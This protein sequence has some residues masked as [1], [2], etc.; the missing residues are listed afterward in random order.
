MATAT[1]LAIDEVRSVAAE[2]LPIQGQPTEGL[3]V[4]ER[5]HEDT[6]IVWPTGPK[7]WVNMTCI[8]VTQFLLGLVRVQSTPVSVQTMLMTP[9][10]I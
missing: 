5:Q 4:E 6:E 3:H 8:L 2:P 1:E 7:L 10:R 9:H